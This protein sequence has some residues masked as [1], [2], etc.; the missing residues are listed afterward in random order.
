MPAP[1]AN[2]GRSFEF[3][4]GSVIRSGGLR[5]QGFAEA[6]KSLNLKPE[7]TN[8]VQGQHQLQARRWSTVGGR[9]ASTLLRNTGGFKLVIVVS[10]FCKGSFKIC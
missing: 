5:L 4:S 10:G 8:P 1:A 6:L 3:F 2:E 9:A 7:I